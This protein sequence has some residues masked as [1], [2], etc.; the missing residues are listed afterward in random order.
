MFAL[1]L[2]GLGKYCVCGDADGKPILYGSAV[3]GIFDQLVEMVE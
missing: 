3:Q 2:Q 1:L